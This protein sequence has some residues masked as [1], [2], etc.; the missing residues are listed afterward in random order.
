MTFDRN[1]IAAL[2][3]QPAFARFLDTLRSERE[4]LRE[5]AERPGA[6]KDHTAGQA[7]GLTRILAEVDAAAKPLAETANGPAGPAE[8]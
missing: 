6:F 1:D 4:L 7:Y 5:Q 3:A 2:H 8:A